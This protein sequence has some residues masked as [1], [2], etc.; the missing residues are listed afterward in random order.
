MKIKS[1][2]WRD[3]GFILVV[4]FMAAIYCHIT[5]MA[6]TIDRTSTV[7]SSATKPVTPG[8]LLDNFNSARSVNAWGVSTSVFSSQSPATANAICTPSYT[9]N[10]AIA[11]GGAGYSLK[12]DYNVDLAKSY[13]GY[14]SQLGSVNLSPYNFTTISF[15]VKGAAGGEFFKI[16]LNTNGTDANRNHAAVYITN[17]LDGGVTTSWRQVTI[18]LRNFANI[19]DW[20]SMKNFV[21][22]FENSQSAQNGSPT[23]GTVYIDNIT[24]GTA[25]VAAVRI[26]PY[27]DKT[28][29]CALGGNMGGD[30]GSGNGTSSYSFS[31][32]TYSGYPNSLKFNYNVSKSGSYVFV[33]HIFGGGSDG[34]QLLPQNFSHYTKLTFDIMGTS[35]G[36]PGGIKIE[37]HDTRTTAAKNGQPFYK[38]TWNGAA[39]ITTAWKHKTIPLASFKDYAGVALKKSAITELVFTL[40]NSNCGANKSGTIYIDNVQF[41]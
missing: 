6:Y 23:H 5:A 9:N 38:I 19:N 30:G 12:L 35:G 28:G 29:I 26:A 3:A 41:N 1:R 8:A 10:S 7:S 20:S 15:W 31:P 27:G 16:E 14:S 18:P 22:T 36:N 4:V 37:L 25:T 11:Y 2:G 39:K 24:F 33:Y 34:N 32:T 13:V 17:F 21:I 40:E